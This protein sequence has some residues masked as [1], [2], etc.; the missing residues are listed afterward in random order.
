MVPKRNLGEPPKHLESINS[1]PTTVSLSGGD[2]V[3]VR[4]REEILKTL[5]QNGCLEGMPFMPEMFAFCGKRCRVQARAHKTCDTVF[6]V[7]GRRVASAVHLETRCDGQAHGGCQ[8]RCLIFW[9]EAWLKRAEGSMSQAPAATAQPPVLTEPGKAG[10]GCTEADVLRAAR[11]P[12]G[13]D[14]SSP[15]YSCQ[16]TRLPYATTHLHHWDVRQYVE[17]YTSGNVGFGAIAAGFIYMGYRGLINL[18]IG[19]GRPLRWVYDKW[20][21]LWGGVPYPRRCGN[22]PVG[23]KTPA[24]ELNLQAGDWVRVRSYEAILATLD[25]A[26]KNRGLY[27]DAEMVPYCAGIYRVLQRVSRIVNEQTG[28][29]QELK[30]PCIMLEGVVCGSRYS[31]CRLFCPRAIYSYWREIWLE[32]VDPPAQ[33]AGEAKASGA[34]K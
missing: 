20:Q 13:K 1:M 5:D 29:I 26:N 15:T 17:D 21:A 7:R 9:K 10:P 18:G 19:L 32:R 33:V 34:S 2:W 3:E 23:T 30:H 22:I 12:A 14:E 4:S 25:Q 6:P 8:A 24:L 16:A 27:F 11:A 28:Q 31:E